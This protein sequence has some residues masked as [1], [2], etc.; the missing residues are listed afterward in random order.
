MEISWDFQRL[1]TV[2]VPT[3]CSIPIPLQL[4]HAQDIK[5][6]SQPIEDGYLNLANLTYTDIG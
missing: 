2:V 4:G 5:E 3:A 6:G 1:H